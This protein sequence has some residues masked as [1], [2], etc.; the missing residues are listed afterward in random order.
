MGQGGVCAGGGVAVRGHDV[1]CLLRT[2][3]ASLHWLL[4]SV[5]HPSTQAQHSTAH[6]TC[7]APHRSSCLTLHPTPTPQLASLPLGE[8]V[9]LRGDGSGPA[10]QAARAAAAAA[11]ERERTFKRAN[12]HRPH[13]ASSKRPVPRLREVIEPAHRC[14]RHAA[15]VR[16]LVLVRLASPGSEGAA[17]GPACMCGALLRATPLHLALC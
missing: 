1:H 16:A 9:A 2:W 13:E 5:L 4:A 12:K 3:P 17:R 7:A 8:R 15:C 6:H 11:R 14:A 10:G